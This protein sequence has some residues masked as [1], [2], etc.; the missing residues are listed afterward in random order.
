MEAL[1]RRA[2][3]MVRDTQNKIQSKSV[4]SSSKREA[5]Y[6]EYSASSAKKLELTPLLKTNVLGG[7][8]LTEDLSFFDA[9]FFNMSS[10]VASVRV[11]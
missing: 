7:H 2:Q 4:L 5:D 1:R 10:E 8:F 6:C 9:S 3:C 11:L